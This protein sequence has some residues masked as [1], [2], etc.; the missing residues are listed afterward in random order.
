MKIDQKT[1]EML[2]EMSDDRLWHTMRMLAAGKGMEIPERMR[3]RIRYDAVRAVLAGTTSQDIQRINELS[4]IY[5]SAKRK[6]IRR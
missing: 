4:E 3:H 2:L 6:G 1:I 5:D